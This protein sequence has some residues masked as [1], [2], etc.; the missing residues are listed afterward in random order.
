MDRVHGLRPRVIRSLYLMYPPFQSRLQCSPFE[1][2]PD[3]VVGA[4]C[5]LHWYQKVKNTWY[6]Y[7]KFHRQ[8]NNVCPYSNT[9]GSYHPHTKRKKDYLMEDS[10]IYHNPDDGCCV[11]QI[12][13]NNFIS[14]PVIMG[15]YLVQVAVS[16]GY[17]MRYHK[18]K[19]M[20]HSENVS[21]KQKAS[22]VTGTPV[23]LDPITNIKVI[24]WWDPKYPR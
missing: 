10:N 17:I 14:L 12:V 23:I 13:S 4:R 2:D 8:S 5:V 21:T 18:V 22:L 1:T 19:L 11:L 3:S 20:F 9:Q 6:F 7:F 16:V 15:Q 24:H